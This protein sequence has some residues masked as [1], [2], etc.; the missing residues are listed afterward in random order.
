ME[1]RAAMQQALQPL[2]GAIPHPLAAAQLAHA[3]TSSGSKRKEEAP[4]LP[5]R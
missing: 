5:A 2:E 1:C 4:P 3:A